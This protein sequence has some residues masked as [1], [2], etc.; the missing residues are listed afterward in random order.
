MATGAIALTDVEGPVCAMDH[1]SVFF[2]A[3]CS[4][5]QWRWCAE[6]I[7]AQRIFR[8]PAAQVSYWLRFLPTAIEML[9]VPP[10]EHFAPST[11]LLRAIG[12]TNKRCTGAALH[13]MDEVLGAMDEAIGAP[14]L[15]GASTSSPGRPALGERRRPVRMPA[16]PREPG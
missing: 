3:R 12:I 5:T 16:P 8:A 9:D 13:P 4:R 10:P 14:S 7:V 11:Q 1:M 6:I 2:R 15:G